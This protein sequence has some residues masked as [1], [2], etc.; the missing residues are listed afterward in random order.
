MDL[1]IVSSHENQQRKTLQVLHIS[2]S[3]CTLLPLVLDL[4]GFQDMML[5]QVL[6]LEASSLLPGQWDR[7]TAERMRLR[8]S[9]GR[10]RE[11]KR[12]RLSQRL[13]SLSIGA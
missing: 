13:K 6:S 4:V 2:T 8:D 7:L 9:A 10:L 3:R 11:C 5:D 12:Q 1:Y